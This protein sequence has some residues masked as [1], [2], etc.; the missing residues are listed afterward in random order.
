MLATAAQSR[1][2]PEPV[3]QRSPAEIGVDA[4][5]GLHQPRTSG[6]IHPVEKPGLGLYHL[7][8]RMPMRVRSARPGLRRK[9]RRR[10]FGPPASMLACRMPIRRLTVGRFAPV[11][12]CSGSFLPPKFCGGQKWP[13]GSERKRLRRVVYPPPPPVG[14]RGKKERRVSRGFLQIVSVGHLHCPGRTASPRLH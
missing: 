4:V 6:G 11:A 5:E 8:D 9:K 7:A 1:D 2:R 10:A 13:V 3:D 12:V 14:V